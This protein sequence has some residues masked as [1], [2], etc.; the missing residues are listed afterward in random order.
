VT[1]HGEILIEQGEEMEKTRFI[2]ESFYNDFK[3]PWTKIVLCLLEVWVFPAIVCTY[4]ES[5]AKLALASGLRYTGS[6]SISYP[7]QRIEEIIEFKDGFSVQMKASLLEPMPQGWEMRSLREFQKLARA[8]SIRVVF[9][10]FSKL[11]LQMNLQISFIVILRIQ[12]KHASRSFFHAHD[13][14][15]NV[16]G[17]ISIM[18]LFI[19][20]SVEFLDVVCTVR[21]FYRVWQAVRGT[22]TSVGNSSK[23]YAEDSFIVE[24]DDSIQSIYYSGKDLKEEYYVV[25]RAFWQL[26]LIT[27]F[28]AWLISYALLKFTCSEVCKHGGWNWATGCLN[29]LSNDTEDSTTCIESLP[30]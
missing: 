14:K 28:S 9:I 15:I 7:K 19:V 29:P 13:W 3:T 12:Q 2:P 17:L 30:F 5:V 20:F 21:V 18:S 4:R 10:M 27:V 6:M 8:H 11:A 23:V 26:F 16:T 22:V 24:E 25:L 1:N